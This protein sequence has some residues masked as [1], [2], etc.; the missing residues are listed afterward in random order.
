[1]FPQIA[2]ESRAVFSQLLF[3]FVIL[4]LSGA[5]IGRAQKLNES[6]VYSFTNA[7]DGNYPVGGVIRGKDGSLYGT[8]SY[9]G[10]NGAGMLY[11]INRNGSGYRALRSFD[12]AGGSSPSGLIQGTNGLL[13][14]TATVNGSNGVGAIFTINT[15]GTGYAQLHAF[16]HVD[17]AYPASGLF[18]GSNGVLYGVTAQGGISNAGTV[19]RMNLDGSGFQVLRQFTNSPDGADPA[20]LV[21][22]SDGTLYGSTVTGGA[23]GAGVIFRMSTNG[24]NY[25][26]LR[27]FT[28]SPDGADPE[29]NLIIGKDGFLYGTTVFGG[30]VYAYGGT[31]FKLNTNGSGYVILHHFPTIAGDGSN[32]DSLMQ[33][34]DG[35]IYGVAAN[36]GAFSGGMVFK[37]DT[38]GGYTVVYGFTNS[39]PDGRN[40][41][42]ALVDAGDGALYGTADNGGVYDHGA[43]FRL[44]PPLSLSFQVT[45]A[46]GTNT[47]ILSW[48]AWASDYAVRASATLTNTSWT[49]IGVPV[50]A[51]GKLFITNKSTA[52]NAFFRLQTGP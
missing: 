38:N 23:A 42:S 51:G 31:L 3:L 27:S 22:G 30:N 6:I 17:G 43:V 40:P 1:M 2:R 15:N 35:S 8:T 44:T 20:A 48:P 33:A 4:T 28:N 16:A 5:T 34:A 29:A 21:Q 12:A 13:Y 49:A 14:G 47:T 46:S 7:P 39:P 52:P 32:P 10:T 45:A 19:F 25:T 18:Q 37:L 50:A 26:I 11:Q 36:T 24:N 9:G 41:V